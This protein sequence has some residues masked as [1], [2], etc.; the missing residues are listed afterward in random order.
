[1]DT[2]ASL[3]SGRRLLLAAVALIVADLIGGLL[4]ISAGLN[5]WADAWVEPSMN[6]PW[7]M[8]AAQLVLALLAAGDARSSRVAAILLAVV[9][10]ISV[11]FG[12]FDGDLTSDDLSGWGVV[13]GLFLVAITAVVGLLAAGRARQ[14]GSDR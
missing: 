13:W 6:T 3:S 12:L 4:S 2:L 5:T 1:M 10:A 9:C 14:L 7:Y 11:L 8:M